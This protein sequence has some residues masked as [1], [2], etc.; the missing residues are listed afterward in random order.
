MKKFITLA[1][2]LLC[3]TL[4]E[5]AKPKLPKVVIEWD[6]PISIAKGGY[7]RVHPM[8]DG[9]LMC[10]YTGGGSGWIC[11]SSDNGLTWTAPEKVISRFD[12]NTDKG[13]A[14]VFISN[15]E[16]LQLSP[17]N[18]SHPGRIIYCFNLRPKD[19]KSS[20]YPF[21]IGYVFSDDNGESW[22]PMTVNYSSDIWEEDKLKG[23]WE[24]FALELPDGT[25]QMYF[26][27]ETPYW[28]DG[29]HY[30]N[31]SLVESRDGGDSWGDVRIA[32]Y[33]E[34]NR[35]G[36]PSAMIYEGNIYLCIETNDSEMKT[37]L[38]PQ[39][40]YNSLEDNWKE[41]V[42]GYSKR[43]F[44]PQRFSTESTEFTTGAPY[45]C[46]TENF[47]V[48]SF[49]SSEYGDIK[50]SK[51]RVCVVQACP[52]SEMKGQIF[53]TMRGD[54]KPIDVD[55]SEGEVKWNSVCPLGADEIMVCC[56]YNGVVTLV[57]GRISTL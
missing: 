27:D 15:P 53:T 24:P 42:D 25:V 26:S 39:I 17:S 30:Q 13:A 16:T 52:I 1:L 2:L 51:Q 3:A 14:T 21:S 45:L 34:K 37:R 18:P 56:Q 19:N 35:D 8:N 48:M 36:M 22:S 4:A 31:I 28:R 40:M 44:C 7:A 33:S 50:D 46:R 29:R 49:Q 43:R 55:V 9:R 12:V 23:C 54:S 5:G 20:V 57:R 32:C 10:S 41:C 11:Y 6:S 47:F 38:H